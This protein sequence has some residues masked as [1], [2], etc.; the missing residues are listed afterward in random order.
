MIS[1]SLSLIAIEASTNK[2]VTIGQWVASVYRWMQS[3][4]EDD[5][6]SRAKALD[7]LAS[8]LQILSRRN[9]TLNADQTKLLV[10]FFCSLFE[11]DHKAGVTASV[12]ALRC[13]IVM[14]HFQP[15]FG[16]D[17]LQS[18]C[19]LGDDF[20]LQAPA[21]RL[22]IYHMCWSLLEIPAVTS[23]LEHRH[24][25]TSG[26]IIHLLNLCRN[27]RDPEN[28][29]M[30]FAILKLFLRDF[31]PSADVTPEIFKAF[32]AY[33]PISLRPSA[34]P[35]NVTTDN[36][37][38]ALR[39]CFSAHHCVASL[40]IPFLVDKLDK[41]DQTVAVKVD[42]LLTLDACLVKYDH[43]KQSVVPHAYQ[44]W[45]SLKYEVRNGEIQDI[46]KATL[47]VLCSLT[48][49]LDGEYL[50]SFLDNAW[51]DLKEDITD[52]RYTA[53][54][55][56]LLVAIS[57][58]PQSF[59]LLMPRAIE[60]IKKSIKQNT[61]IIHKRHLI[62]LT[63]SIVKLRL[64]LV[65]DLD[66][67]QSQTRDEDLLSDDLFGDSLF[68]EVYL[69]LWEEHSASSSS[70]IEYVSILQETMKGLGSLAGQK[71]SGKPPI[72]RL[73]SDSTCETIVNLLAQLVIIS[74]LKG[75]MNFDLIEDQVYQDLLDAGAEALSDAIPLY[76]PSFYYLLLHYL[77]SVKDAYSSQ[78][79]SHSLG[80]RI[81]NVS[82]TLC[83][84]MYPGKLDPNRC[85]F[86]EAALIN[87]FLQGLQWMLS[88][89]ADPKILV[90]FI[91]AI[92]VALKQALKQASTWDTNPELTKQIFCDLASLFEALDVPQVDLNRPGKIQA[93]DDGKPTFNH[94][95]RV[96][97]LLVVQQLY[98]RFTTLGSPVACSIGDLN[99]LTAVTLSDDLDGG[100]VALISRQDI[101]L[102]QLG[103][104]AS[105][106]VRSF[107]EEEQR[108]LELYA[109]AFSLFHTRDDNSTFKPTLFWSVS[110]LNGFRTA[111]L[112]LGIIQG[113]WP[114][115]ISTE[116]S[117]N[118]E[119]PIG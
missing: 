66:L 1:N 105:S 55:G 4:G 49:R 84:L 60:H 87:T 17:I 102:N 48:K 61:S 65:S 89:R 23:D 86:N 70:P 114:G 16:S 28:L 52:S 82:G 63:N 85:W 15:S 35:S 41:V 56:R 25:S 59:A 67:D 29:M 73:C 103:Q 31:N 94:P 112:V 2:R 115:A 91:D 118:E 109:E 107:S 79:Q 5:L 30:W 90:V 99:K 100:D 64:H 42:I 38:V 32:S 50:E 92:H 46:I 47:K 14:K 119:N 110:P 88:E 80:S 76:P 62:A 93:L 10:T 95:R 116:V 75:L 53:Q 54:A 9:D 13:L 96:Y 51:R 8:T 113:L 12:K 24:G 72:R 36:L 58:S 40:S 69:P 11:N 43:P 78:A 22:E 37:K 21:T 98:R 117:S 97:Y 74:P 19:K 44:I 34:T 81:R 18:V 20:K 108:G 111:P 33:F 83:T 104:L 71:S 45:N 106:V 39:S 7:F 57:A 68:H 26:S 6:I 101:L 77:A 27:E 3:S